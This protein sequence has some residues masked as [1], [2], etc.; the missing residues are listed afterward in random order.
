MAGISDKAVKTEYAINKYRYNGKELQNQEFSDGTGLEEYD[1][2]ARLQ[3]PQLGRFWT[4]DPMAD[5]FFPLS[6][7]SYVANNPVLINDPTGKDWSITM[8]QDKKGVTH[9][10]ILFTG[11]VVDETSDQKGQADKIASAIT[12]QFQSLFNEDKSKDSKNGFTVDAKA[13]IRSVK[14]EKDVADNE[15]VFKIENSNSDDL[16]YKDDKGQDQYAAGAALNG[17]TI[18]INENI[19]PDVIAGNANKPIPHEIGHTGGLHHPEDDGGFL[20]WL[21]NKPGYGL[22]RSGNNFMFAGGH[23]HPADQL[24]KS[25]TGPTQSQLYHIYQLYQSGKLNRKDIDPTKQ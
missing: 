1:F 25:P 22:E 9:F 3:D 21:F 2:G 13:E 17:K 14:S 4:I 23:Y 5:K 18:A 24:N 11:A 15:T 7:Y 12:A 8:D 6:P 19:V 20:G 16:K 10:H